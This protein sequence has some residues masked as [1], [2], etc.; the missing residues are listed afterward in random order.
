[1]L[2]TKTS[3]TNDIFISCFMCLAGGLSLI[4][5]CD[6]AIKPVHSKDDQPKNHAAKSAP[7]AGQVGSNKLI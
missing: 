7:N 6:C 4:N 5:F 3:G 1:M 2:F